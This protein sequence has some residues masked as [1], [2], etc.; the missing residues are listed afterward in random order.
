MVFYCWEAR[1]FT[2]AMWDFLTSLVRAE[3]RNSSERG[4][5]GGGDERRGEVRVALRAHEKK[6]S[7]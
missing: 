3:S 7:L 1:W 6:K 4:E 5:E 2:S